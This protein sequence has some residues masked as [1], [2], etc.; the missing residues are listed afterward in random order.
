MAEL[1]LEDQPATTTEAPTKKPRKPRKP[2]TEA[3]PEPQDVQ[4]GTQEPQGD[5]DATQNVQSTVEITEASQNASQTA[6]AKSDELAEAD[7]F[8][9]RLKS[10]DDKIREADVEIENLKSKLKSAKARQEEYVGELRE[11]VRQGR[12][13]GQPMPLFDRKPEPAATEAPKPSVKLHEPWREWSLAKIG[14]S[15]GIV[16]KLAEAGYSTAGQIA[17]FSSKGGILTDIA[18]IGE[19]TA[20]KIDDALAE[21]HR[22]KPWEVDGSVDVATAMLSLGP[23]GMRL[24]DSAGDEEPSDESEP[25]TEGFDE[26]ELD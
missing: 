11:I 1:E 19:A 17:G 23:E 15:D 26:D 21:M 5:A 14:L 8:E 18:G 10:A 13:A 24:E 12:H 9:R 7:E 3:T 20:D 16:E 4:E 22:I 25:E 6:S 2:K